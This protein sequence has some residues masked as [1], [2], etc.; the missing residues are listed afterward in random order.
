[1]E[2]SLDDIFKPGSSK[3]MS[4]SLVSRGQTAFFLLCWGWD[5]PTPTQKEK[6]RS[7]HVKLVFHM[8]K[9]FRYSKTATMGL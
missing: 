3:F 2:I 8:P 6:K 5:S 9:S 1:M 7:S 4:G